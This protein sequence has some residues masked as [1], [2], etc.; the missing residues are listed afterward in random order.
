MP[1]SLV[2]LLLLLLGP[3]PGAAQEL[4]IGMKAAVD[5]SD[6]HQS[7]S[8]NR[9]VQLHVYEPLVFQDPHLRPVPGLATAWRAPDAESWEFTLR[10]GVRFHDGTPLTP[11]DVAFSIRR[12]REATGLRTYAPLVRAVTAV[13]VV[14]ART[15][16]IRTRAPAPM[17]PSALA[18]IGIV[19]AAAVG[20]AGEAEFNGGRAAIGTGPYRLSAYRPG[21]RAERCERTGR[22]GGAPGPRP[23]CIEPRASRF[24]QADVGRQSKPYGPGECRLPVR[25]ARRGAGRP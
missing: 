4:R 3:W 20:E 14:D 7:Y 15:V 25:A 8:P 1:R 17:L 22:R 13:E 6:P 18:S 24:G 9:N 10:E 2:L 12:A 19:S 16:R 21:D 23:A 5:G 11:A